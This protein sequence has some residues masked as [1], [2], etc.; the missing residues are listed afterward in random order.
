M[1]RD[2]NRMK[3]DTLGAEVSEA[4]LSTVPATKWGTA[5]QIE[6]AVRVRE[7][8]DKLTDDQW[9]VCGLKAAGYTAIQIAETRG[10]SPDAVNMV[11]SRAKRKL[12]ILL[13]PLPAG[14]LDRGAS[15]PSPSA[16]PEPSAQERGHDRLDGELPPPS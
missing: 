8:Q 16:V 9:L 14:T 5:Q 11:F 7:A 13:R 2:A 12:Q 6:D 4:I 15:G 10:G 3:R 1:R